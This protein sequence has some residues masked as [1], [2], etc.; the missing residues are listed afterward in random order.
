MDRTD[1]KLSRPALIGR[2]AELATIVGLF[3]QA[4]AGRGA[5]AL[6]VGAGGVG[7]SR[8]VS[9]VS[10][11]V[12]SMGALVVTSH[13]S[14]FDAGVPYSLLSGLVD[15]LPADQRG[16]IGD[17]VEQIRAH[18][19]R[20][21]VDSSGRRNNVVSLADRLVRLLTL[22]SPLVIV[23]DDL[24]LADDDSLALLTRLSRTFSRTRTMLM[25]T[26]R[27]HGAY[28]SPR[29]G[30]LVGFLQGSEQG[31]VIDLAA[32]DPSETRS[33]IRELLG[34]MPDEDLTS[35]VYS[36]SR[37]NPFFTSEVVRSLFRS[38][39][40]RNSSTRAHLIEGERLPQSHTS[41]I[42]RFFEV[43]SVDTQV[44]R[45]LSTFGRIELSRL[46]AI[47]AVSGLSENVIRESFDRLVAAG[48]L[49]DEGRSGFA[50]THSLLRESLYD[51]IGP[52]EQRRLHHSIAEYF[53]GER[54]RGGVVDETELATHVSASAEKGDTRAIAILVEAGHRVAQVAPLAA[55]S[56]FEQAARLADDDPALRAVLAAERA[57][58]LFR[59][60]RPVESVTIAQEALADL[61]PGRLRNRTISDVVNCLY[62]SGDLQG[63]INFIECQ[64][65]VSELPLSVRAQ[66]EHFLVQ[67]GSVDRRRCDH[68]LEADTASGTQ[69]TVTLAHDMF[70]AAI[71]DRTDLIDRGV[72]RIESW[73]STASDSVRLATDSFLSM[74]FLTYEDM[75]SARNVLANWTAVDATRSNMSLSALLETTACA[76]QYVHGEWDDALLYADD[77][78]WQMETHGVRIVEAFLRS[79]P[80]RILLERGDIRSARELS[81]K[82]FTVAHGMKPTVESVVAHIERASGRPEKGIERL[83]RLLDEHRLFGISIQ[84]HH[85]LEELSQCYLAARLENEAFRTVDRLHEEWADSK[86]E[87]VSCCANLVHGSIRRDPLSLTT[88]FDIARREGFVFEEGKSRLMLAEI[89]VDAPENFERSRDLFE[90]LGALPWRQQSQ[91]GLRRLGI[92][93]SRSTRRSEKGLTEAET[94]IAGLVAQGMTNKEIAAALHYSVKTVEVYLTRV[95]AKTGSSSRIELARAVDSGRLSL[96]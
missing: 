27:V 82:L 62:I 8:L 45:V 31:M 72:E 18:I 53:I 59:A 1:E 33:V 70:H 74:A 77:L 46:S 13:S 37:G 5:A 90:R 66:Y 19:G 65:D 54:A 44:A 11:R 36:S 95:Y 75:K 14:T 61:E 84:G 48:L 92:S 34:T 71:I 15:D 24:H 9:E 83:T 67:L 32:L 89:G 63:V 80:S 57:H 38:G 87:Y 35:F 6:V 39:R 30:D 10:L 25:G 3:K 49:H 88:A 2:E 78:L 43:G 79:V 52:A 76:L 81:R 58:A 96:L 51:D 23:A 50:F 17:V 68:F 28:V 7:K 20:S 64:G 73:R 29:I 94:A 69:E 93:S 21:L 42:H 86:F 41:L 91:A 55:A 56:W 4:E 16:E 26:A 60:S 40:I 85:I 47:E 22:D 12:E